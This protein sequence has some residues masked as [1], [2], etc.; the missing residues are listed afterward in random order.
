MPGC[1]GVA[2]ALT[3]SILGVDA[4]QL[5]TAATLTVPLVADGMTVMLGLLLVPVHPPGSV[6]AYD[7]A[8]ATGAMLY[9]CCAPLHTTVMPE[10]APGVAGVLAELTASVCKA[11][12]PQ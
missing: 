7:T 10:I 5:D 1:G 11:E 12:V 3:T 8:P 6:Q 2:P 9:V 4:P